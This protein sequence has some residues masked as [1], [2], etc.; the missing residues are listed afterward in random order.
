MTRPCVRPGSECEQTAG[1]QNARPSVHQ[2]E[3]SKLRATAITGLIV[4]APHLRVPDRG[5]ELTHSTELVRKVE[6]LLDEKGI[7]RLSAHV[8]GRAAQPYS[9][10]RPGSRP[11]FFASS[12]LG[13]PSR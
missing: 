11:S 5:S 12:C 6:L 9:P 1:S 13:V 8:R 3:T 10:S 7:I 2:A 4:V